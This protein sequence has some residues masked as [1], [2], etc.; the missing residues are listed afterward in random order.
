MEN[1]VQLL[2][3]TKIFFFS[4]RQQKGIAYMIILSVRSNSRTAAA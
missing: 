1:T 3:W 2:S 4:Q